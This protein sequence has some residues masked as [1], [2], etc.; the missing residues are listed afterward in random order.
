MLLEQIQLPEVCGVC[1]KSDI[2][3]PISYNIDDSTQI[4]IFIKC[5][6]CY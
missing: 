1:Y 6:M 5:L 2:R 3:L 4:L